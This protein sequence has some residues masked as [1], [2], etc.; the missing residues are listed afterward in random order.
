MANR[1]EGK[2]AL[3][4]GSTSGIGRATATLFAAEGAR[5]VVN[6]RR[7]ELGEAVVAE[8]KR[9][10]GEAAYYQADVSRPEEVRSLVR[11]AVERYGRL[12]VLMNNALAL[13]RGTAVELSEAEWDQTMAVLLKAP[14]IACQEAIP[15]M[16]RQGG[17]SIVNTA[18]VHAYLASGR[19]H[20]YDTAKAGL[21]NMTRQIAVDFGPRGIRANA[22]CPGA[23]IVEKAE[24]RYRED[25]DLERQQ[26]LVYPVRR[27]GRPIDVAYAAVYLASDESSFVTGT[28]IVVDGGMTCQLPD[29]LYAGFE[30]YYREALAREWGVRR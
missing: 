23:I 12:D 3:I 15:Q 1:L 8:I 19:W 7:R 6:G 20:A 14:F 13:G 18:S 5:V 4:T 9:A 17:G 11:F 2:V 26:A 24:P 21:V 28:T 27:L 29:T 16:I 22:I 25:P 10:G 30:E